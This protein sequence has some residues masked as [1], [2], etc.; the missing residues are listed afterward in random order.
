MSA[1]NISDNVRLALNAFQ[2]LL[3]GFDNPETSQIKDAFIREQDRFKVWVGNIGAHKRGQ[4]S[5]DYR[6]RDASHLQHGVQELLNNLIENLSE[7]R[8]GNLRSLKRHTHTHSRPMQ[9]CH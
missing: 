3:N 2:S 9:L 6:L 5:L 7:G 4:S 1:Q 8:T